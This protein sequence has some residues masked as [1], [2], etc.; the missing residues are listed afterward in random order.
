[1]ISLLKLLM[2][3]HQQQ[4]KVFSILKKLIKNVKKEIMLINDKITNI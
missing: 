1:M 2:L 3:L 4:V